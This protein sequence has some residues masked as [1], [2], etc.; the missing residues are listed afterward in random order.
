M[1]RKGS[2]VRLVSGALVVGVLLASGGTASAEEADAEQTDDAALFKGGTDALAGGKPGEAIA[3]LEALA[4]RGVV[5][6]VV[7]YD[8]G[9]A[10]AA[11]VRAGAE[12]PGDLGRATH[13]FEEARDLTRDTKLKEDASRA[14]AALRSEMAR[15]R[16]H[17]GDPIEIEHGFS[18]GRSIVTLLPENAWATIA[19]AMAL[20]L[21][22][23]IVVRRLVVLPRARVA[24]TTSAALAGLLLVLS[25][26]LVWAARDARLHLKEG[27][28]IAPNARLLDARHLALDGVAPLPEGVRAQI[29]DEGS[30]FSRIVVGGAEGYLPS[31]AVLPLAR[32]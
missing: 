23:A 21:T 4:D 13:G 15:R 18:L 10:Y 32:R 8:R 25:S 9:L 12:Q 29:K 28:L 30:G 14:L 27:V 16:S 6:A 26:I 2:F 1:K 11:R 20:F 24:A 22:I 17:A 7:S 19:G 5:D 3:K 31:S